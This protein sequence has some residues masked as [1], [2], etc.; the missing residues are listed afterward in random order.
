MNHAR[1]LA[2]HRTE[3]Q[4]VVIGLATGALYAAIYALQRA[5][6]PL[7]AAGSLRMVG[8]L[9]VAANIGVFLCY[10]AIV[11]LAS[12][13][14]L[15]DER[16]RLLAFGFPLL[17]TVA[18]TLG[19][20]YLS[21]DV[22]TYVSQGH[23]A[24]SGQSPY[25]EPPG[26]I[27]D[28]S[29]GLALER[30]GW[31]GGRDV[32]PYGP[33]WTELEAAVALA[34]RDIATQ[35]LLLKIVV[36]A[37]ALGSALLVWRILGALSPRYQVLGT[38]LYLWNPVVVMELSGEGHNEA[39]AM[40]FVLLSLY[41][42]IRGNA[43]DGIV[44]AAI[45]A[46]IK[47]GAL[48]FTP[49]ALVYAWRTRRRGLAVAVVTGSCAAAAIAVVAYG[50]LWIGAATFDGIRAHAWP[51]LMSASTPGVLYEY[52]TRRLPEPAAARAVALM[53]AAGFLAYVAFASVKIRDPA[54]LVRASGRVAL[55]YLML[56]PGYWPW[57]AA[58]PV[59]LLAL[60]PDET[61]IWSILAVS[62]GSRLAAPLDVL[63]V[64]DVIDWDREMLSATI[65]GVWFPAATIGV[66]AARDAWSDW[67]SRLPTFTLG[68]NRVRTASNP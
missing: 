63:R 7:H 4:T 35:V 5:M 30:E 58:T 66:L 15:R 27:A 8:V 25:A 57:Y 20:P 56:A 1:T 59:A 44:G 46:L 67:K 22:L 68:R 60:A 50:P 62:L 45:G 65:V 53:M 49:L 19:R 21:T 12:A 54:S 2:V 43:D 10:A 23:Q 41:F 26:A 51:N 33:L 55:V 52:L 6:S 34:T 39:V 31:P 61:A 13:G 11:S 29:F 3:R 37:F 9:Y 17:F 24:I 47:I 42:W 32:S 36:T 18:L 16:G 38:I 64:N 28:T 40:F 48:V 14:A